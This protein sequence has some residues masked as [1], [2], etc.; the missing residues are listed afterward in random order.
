M[1]DKMTIEASKEEAIKFASDKHN[2]KG[3]HEKNKK[4]KKY[5]SNHRMTVS[6]KDTQS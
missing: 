6:M 3:T 2:L 4:N 5:E 1:I